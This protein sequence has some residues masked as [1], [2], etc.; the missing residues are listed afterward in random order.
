VIFAVLALAVTVACVTVMVQRVRRLRRVELPTAP[1][2]AERARQNSDGASD[3][4]RISLELDEFVRD[5][6]GDTRAEPELASALARV[7]LA[8]GTG[9]ALLTIATNFGFAALPIA[10]TCF[11]VGVVGAMAVSYLGRLAS[12]RSRAIRAHWTDAC[13]KA[14]RQIGAGSR[15]P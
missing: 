5:L 10:G 4:A 15:A 11:G 12:E 9:L 1:E 7:V 3:P 8:S 14:R 13:A 6:D 2:L